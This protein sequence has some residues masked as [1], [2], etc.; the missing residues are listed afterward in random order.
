[1]SS[2]FN[3]RSFFILTL[4]MFLVLLSACAPA[5][6]AD[7]DEGEDEDTLVFADEIALDLTRDFYVETDGDNANSC[8]SLE[9]ACLT[10]LGAFQKSTIG[11]RIH[12][13]AGTFIEP[14]Y[15]SALIPLSHNLTISG[16]GPG[17]TIIDANFA[18]GGMFISPGSSTTEVLL[19]GFTIQ[20]TVRAS[21]SGCIDNRSAATLTVRNVEARNCYRSGITHT[22][23]GMTHLIDVYIHDTVDENAG[24]DFTLNGYGVDLRGTMIIEDSEI[25]NNP[26]NGIL[27]GAADLTISNTVISTNSAS[28]IEVYESSNLDL[29]GLT[30]NNNSR[31]GILLASSTT[32]VR[33]SDIFAN[34]QSGI[35]LSGGSLRME[36][37]SIRDHSGRALQVSATASANLFE[38]SITNNGSSA[39]WVPTI[40]NAGRMGI[41][42]SN[43]DGNHQIAIYNTAASHVIITDSSFSN[44][45]SEDGS[46]L[47]LPGAQ[48]TLT[49]VLVADNRT[50]SSAALYD[51]GGELTATNIT[52]SNNSGVGLRSRAPFSI[53]YATIAENGGLGTVFE[54]TGGELDNT[55]I[56]GNS[57]GDCNHP[58]LDML[59]SGTNIDT[60]SS[61]GFS[62]TYA[63]AALLLG[64]LSDNDG[65][66]RTHALAE[67]SPAVD[68]ASASCPSSDQ[69]SFARPASAADCDVG[70]YEI[71]NSIIAIAPIVLEESERI[72][73]LPLDTDD[74]PIAIALRNAACREGADALFEIIDF[75][76]EGQTARLVGQILEGA[77]FKVEL[78]GDQERCWIF[79][80][81]LDLLGSLENLPFLNPPELPSIVEPID[82]DEG[83]SANSDEGGDSSGNNNN[84]NNNSGNNNAS[85]P[86]APSNASINNWICTSQNYEV[87]IG[88]KDNSNDE[89]GF[90]I[91]RSGNLIATLGANVDKYTDHP[92]GSGPYLF[93]IEAFNNSGSASTTV[94][95]GGCL[96]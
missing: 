59:L 81:N 29:T 50:G 76:F 92:P 41:Q 46:L 17:I 72:E 24:G 21:A 2:T 70:A 57:G 36:N 73:I 26:S 88:W 8:F 60:D 33:D 68:A 23:T 82:E 95:E 58:S 40:W 78:D 75:L 56:A 91:Y 32:F 65:F 15:G 74:D 31:N 89:D 38:V 44:N 84:G 96:P 27:A 79:S 61:C 85:T 11:D 86:T 39:E 35:F 25:S 6:D 49:R 34:A 64:P 54:G 1:M 43:V 10:I 28:G 3:T 4:A 45:E 9:E 18:E 55:I 22:G 51:I 14:G 69:R 53:S 83:D 67:A 93:T 12:V 71:S 20:N 42:R 13:G 80:E 5:A 63:S 90:R 66:T 62:A 19:E 77:W 16:A 47:I 52:V 37:S 48:A 7:S 87:L 94:N 30:V